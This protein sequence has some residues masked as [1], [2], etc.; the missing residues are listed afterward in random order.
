[1]LIMYIF[2]LMKLIG[3]RHFFKRLKDDRSYHSPIIHIYF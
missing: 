1:M 2:Y 3:A